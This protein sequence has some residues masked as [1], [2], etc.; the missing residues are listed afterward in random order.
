MKHVL[1]GSTGLVHY[2]GPGV[3]G[4]VTLCGIT[5]WLGRPDG[6]GKLT[7][8]RVTCAACISVVDH[9]NDVH[10]TPSASDAPTSKRMK[11][12]AP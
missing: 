3:L 9:V 8:R 1:E 2:D 6:D 7:K 5:D 12:A 4:N 10:F 11:G